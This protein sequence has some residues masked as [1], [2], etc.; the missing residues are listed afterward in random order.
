MRANRLDFAISIGKND[1]RT[2]GLALVC[3]PGAWYSA[4]IKKHL[5]IAEVARTGGKARAHIPQRL[6][7]VARPA[8]ALA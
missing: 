4:A 6:I 1:K 2:I 5:T 7:A 3:M 8:H